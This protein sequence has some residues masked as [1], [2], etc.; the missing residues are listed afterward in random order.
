ML[1]TVSFTLYGIFF[2][3]GM[4]AGAKEEARHL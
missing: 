4:I 3:S 1:F 2:T